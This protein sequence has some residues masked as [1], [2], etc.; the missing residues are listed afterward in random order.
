[1]KHKK[2]IDELK[3]LGVVLVEGTNHYKAYYNGRQTV[4]NRHP[5]HEYSK[6]YMERIKRQLGIKK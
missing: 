5:T 4:V 1:M 2:F 6:L 3:D